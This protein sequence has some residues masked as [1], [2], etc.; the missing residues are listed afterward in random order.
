MINDQKVLAYNRLSQIV[1]IKAFKIVF[2][3]SS[4]LRSYVALQLFSLKT[5][6]PHL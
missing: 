4:A 2:K 3:P 1:R 5:F 6:F